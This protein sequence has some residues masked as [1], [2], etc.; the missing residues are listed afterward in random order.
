MDTLTGRG[1]A[2]VR[3]KRTLLLTSR[4]CGGVG[5]AQCILVLLLLLLRPHLQRG[6]SLEIL[7]YT[8]TV[9]VER[10]ADGLVELFVL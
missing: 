6:A 5:A 9:L 8:S 10:F 1:S 4:S 3:R 2:A 7:L